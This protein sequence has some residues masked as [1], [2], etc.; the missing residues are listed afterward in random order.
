MCIELLCSIFGNTEIV[1][2][3][4]PHIIMGRSVSDEFYE[5]RTKLVV[6]QNMIE[7]NRHATPRDRGF[8]RHI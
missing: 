6:V 4:L 3:V 1:V 5:G 7:D 2:V 8:L